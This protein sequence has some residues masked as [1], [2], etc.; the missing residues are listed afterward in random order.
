[1]L[2]KHSF[3]HRVRIWTLLITCSVA[4]IMIFIYQL[5]RIE[6]NSMAPLLSDREAIL[7]NKIVY[8]L[9]PIQR[10]DVV[11]FDYPLDGTQ[12]F[13]KRIVALPG[14]IVEIRQGLVYVNG[15]RLVQIPGHLLKAGSYLFVRF[16]NGNGPNVN[17]IQVFNGDRSQ[18]IATIQTVSVERQNVSG[19][20]VLMFADESKNG[21]APVVVDWFYPGSLEGHEFVYSGHQEREVRDAPQVIV[22]SNSKGS[23]PARNVSGD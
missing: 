4:P 15:N 5:A 17:L 16:D 21:R 10:G 13:I 6:G 23:T 2:G 1:M 22:A 14:E 19:D 9:D 8:H 12:S 7:V 11:V 3:P 18:L 20:T